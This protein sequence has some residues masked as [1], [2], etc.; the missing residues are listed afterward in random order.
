MRMLS[1]KEHLLFQIT[2]NNVPQHLWATRYMTGMVPGTEDSAK[3]LA[4]RELPHQ[5]D[6]LQTYVKD[7]SSQKPSMINKSQL[8][9]NGCS[10][11]FWGNFTRPQLLQQNKENLFYTL[12]ECSISDDSWNLLNV[13]F[14]VVCK[15]FP[16]PINKYHQQ[17]KEKMFPLRI[18]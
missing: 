10:A 9:K 1:G 17:P 18:S 4:L 2:Q 6:S 12:D 16:E 15:S 7:M 13:F 14:R 3:P 11:G 8:G 5:Q